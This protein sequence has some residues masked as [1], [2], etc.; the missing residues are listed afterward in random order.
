V[1][2]FLVSFILVVYSDEKNVIMPLK[3]LFLKF[4]FGMKKTGT[5]F[6]NI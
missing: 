5:Q 3:S 6:P 4:Y 1:D 2:T